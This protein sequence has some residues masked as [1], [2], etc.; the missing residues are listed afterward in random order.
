MHVPSEVFLRER[1][2][3]YL[4][5]AMASIGALMSGRPQSQSLEIWDTSLKQMIGRLEIDN[6][7]ARNS[8]VFKAVGET[9]NCPFQ[10]ASD[11]ELLSGCS[12]RPLDFSVLITSSGELRGWHIPV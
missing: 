11:A 2:P 9:L 12:W 6:S 4:T 5:L 8:D 7:E 3:E 1:R 10:L